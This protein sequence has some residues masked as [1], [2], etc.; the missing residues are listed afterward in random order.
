MDGWWF[1][2]RNFGLLTPPQNALTFLAGV[3]VLDGVGR[4]VSP[5]RPK[6]PTQKAQAQS[7]AQLLTPKT[8]RTVRCCLRNLVGPVSESR[9]SKLQENTGDHCGAFLGPTISGKLRWKLQ[10]Y[11]F[12]EDPPALVC[13]VLHVPSKWPALPSGWPFS[14]TL[15]TLPLLNVPRD[16][17]VF[18]LVPRNNGYPYQWN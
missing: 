7:K 15:Q 18:Y 17:A 13:R 11:P 6:E 4:Y 12:G 16:C 3:A 10:T 9:M 8:H 14:L 1:G 5:K 2:G